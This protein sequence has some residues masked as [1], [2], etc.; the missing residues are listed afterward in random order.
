MEKQNGNGKFGKSLE[1]KTEKQNR[2]GKFG[3]FLD[4]FGKNVNKRSLVFTLRI[5]ENLRLEKTEKKF[6][7]KKQKKFQTGF[8]G[9]KKT[10]NAVKQGKR[11]WLLYPPTVNFSKK[12]YF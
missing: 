11:F 12:R 4:K 6:L 9:K 2:N 7:K 8:K 10:S 5:Q 1:R 3:K